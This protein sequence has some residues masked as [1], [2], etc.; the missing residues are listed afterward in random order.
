MDYQKKVREY[1]Q[2]AVRILPSISSELKH[3]LKSSER[4]PLFIDNLAVEIK[5]AQEHQIKRGKKPFTTK[6]IKET[7]YSMTELFLNGIETEAQRR[8]ESD[9]KRI[10]REQEIQDQEDLEATSNGRSQGIYEELGV[11]IATD[12]E[13][14]AGTTDEV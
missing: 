5:K 11:Q 13:E 1:Y 8:Y 10:S 2:E 3:S 12:R 6:T 4:V 14:R 9:L 7:V